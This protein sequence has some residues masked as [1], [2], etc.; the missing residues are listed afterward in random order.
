MIKVNELGMLKV[1]KSVALDNKE[2]RN[3]IREIVSGDGEFTE[4]EWIHNRWSCLYNAFDLHY[5]TDIRAEHDQYKLLVDKKASRLAFVEKC[6]MLGK[7]LYIASKMF[8][9][10]FEKYVVEYV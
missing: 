5:N 3:L 1:E 9:N 2:M 6:E 7:L 8:P 10:E 4:A